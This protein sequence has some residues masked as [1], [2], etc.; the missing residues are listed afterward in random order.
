MVVLRP[1]GL[2]SPHPEPLS[3]ANDTLNW[4][5]LNK[6]LMRPARN[7]VIEAPVQ[8]HCFR[9]NHIF[10]LRCSISIQN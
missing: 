8:I 4:G 7:T 2:Y 5:P 1:E 10:T 9:S 3:I 6:S